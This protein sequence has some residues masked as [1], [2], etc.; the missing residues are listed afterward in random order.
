M[1]ALPARSGLLEEQEL[2]AFTRSRFDPVAVCLPCQDNA[3]VARSHTDG[4]VSIPESQGGLTLK[5]IEEVPLCA[6]LVPRV[7]FTDLDQP[8]LLTVVHTGLVAVARLRFALGSFHGMFSQS[9][10]TSMVPS[11]YLR[12]SWRQ[13]S[14]KPFIISRHNLGGSQPP[15]RIRSAMPCIMPEAIR[16]AIF[17]MARVARATSM[18]PSTS[19]KR[20]AMTYPQLAC[21]LI[22]TIATSLRSCRCATSTLAV[23][24]V[25]ALVASAG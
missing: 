16:D 17:G 3:A 18:P 15:S 1:S 14:P 21:S 10:T 24:D 23:P 8:H 19:P 25:Q 11:S 13:A 20:P 2:D 5:H 22:G 4:T 6:P 9:I 12:T 7:P